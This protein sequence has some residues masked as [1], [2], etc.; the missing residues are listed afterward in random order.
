MIQATPSDL[1]DLRLNPMMML[2]IGT[3]VKA[4]PPGESEGE[5]NTTCQAT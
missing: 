3:S 5:I 1:A 2:G 4:H